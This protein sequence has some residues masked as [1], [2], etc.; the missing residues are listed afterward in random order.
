MK[1]LYSDLDT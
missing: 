1:A